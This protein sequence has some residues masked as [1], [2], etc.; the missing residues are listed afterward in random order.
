MCMYAMRHE[1]LAGECSIRFSMES[2]A[3]SNGIDGNQFR[4]RFNLSDRFEYDDDGRVV[5]MLRGSAGWDGGI[6]KVANVDLAVEMGG[7]VAPLMLIHTPASECT[8]VDKFT[9]QP[10]G[11]ASRSRHSIVAGLPGTPREPVAAPIPVES[12]RAG[13]MLLRAMEM[14]E[15]GPERADAQGEVGRIG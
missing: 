8:S 9:R 13:R 15:D 7:D 11:R 3:E 10:P 14:A 6:V 4:L 12:W 1:L 2:M 5:S